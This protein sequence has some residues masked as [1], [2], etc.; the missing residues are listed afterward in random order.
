MTSVCVVCGETHRHHAKGK[1][2]R[3][4]NRDRKRASYVWREIDEIAVERAVRGDPPAG[5]TPRE[6]REAVDVLTRR[7][8]SASQVSQRLRV[9]QRAV[10][11]HRAALRRA[12]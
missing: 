10:E 4:Y 8:F 6:R 7:G 1:C 3:C 12:A 9:S 5:I 11:R 2:M